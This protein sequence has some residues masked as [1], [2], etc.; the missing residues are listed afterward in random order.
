MAQTDMMIL[1]EEKR[2]SHDKWQINPLCFIH[3]TFPSHPPPNSLYSFITHSVTHT[4]PPLS[5]SQS[6]PC[7][8]DQPVLR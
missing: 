3:S 5:I 4:P 2:G 6:P 1:L 8:S 7:S